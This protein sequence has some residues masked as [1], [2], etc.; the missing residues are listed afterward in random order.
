M[1]QLSA[2]LLRVVAVIA[3]F[4]TWVI[5]TLQLVVWVTLG[6]LTKDEVS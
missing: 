6:L 4:V 2:S 1:F 5:N 3:V